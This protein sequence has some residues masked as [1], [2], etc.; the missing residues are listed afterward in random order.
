MSNPKGNPKNLTP[1]KPGQSGNLAGPKPGYKHISTHI[2]EMLNDEKFETLLQDPVS[3]YVEYKGAP[4][5]AII[6]V[7]MH[8]ALHDKEKGQQWAE[9][10]A[11]YGYGS[12]VKVE[13]DDPRKAILAKYG[14]GEDAGQTKKT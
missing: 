11:K 2:Q 6:A 3:G 1:W 7:A 9:W 14:L 12:T 8:K 13:F 10:L 4:I 5:K